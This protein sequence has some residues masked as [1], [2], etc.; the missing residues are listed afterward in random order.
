MLEEKILS[1]IVKYD[2]KEFLIVGG[3]NI[4]EYKK[5]LFDVKGLLFQWD[6]TKK[7]RFP[8]RY[9]YILNF[10]VYSIDNEDAKLELNQ[11]FGNLGDIL[12]IDY[13]YLSDTKIKESYN[14]SYYTGF[15][16]EIPM[17]IYYRPSLMSLLE[18]S[19]DDMCKEYLKQKNN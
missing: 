14:P 19:I 9:S 4:S 10:D 11:L 7:K 17:P 18:E 5:K 3:E 8:R 15:Y 12:Y 16:G 13:N 1:R 6:R 2:D